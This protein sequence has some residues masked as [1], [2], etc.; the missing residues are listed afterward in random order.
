MSEKAHNALIFAQSEMPYELG[1]QRT[2][3]ME[4]ED[5]DEVAIFEGR[6]KFVFMRQQT[7]SSPEG[8]TK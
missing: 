4:D 5:T 7:D 6:T 8:S 2:I 3:K 1:R